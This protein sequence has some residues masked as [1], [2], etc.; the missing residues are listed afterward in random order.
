MSKVEKLIYV[1]AGRPIQ[2][3]MN[4]TNYLIAI[5]WKKIF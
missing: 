4:K 2:T 1:I 5:Y 3:V